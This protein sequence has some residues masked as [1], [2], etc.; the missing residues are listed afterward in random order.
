MIS[1]LCD[2]NDVQPYGIA[3]AKHR[4][5]AR[6]VLDALRVLFSNGRYP[7]ILKKWGVRAGVIAHPEIN[8]AIR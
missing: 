7:A 4:G 8:A 6:P 2:H 3:V 1:D 5:L